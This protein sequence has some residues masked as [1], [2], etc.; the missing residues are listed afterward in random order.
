MENLN[1]IEIDGT[2]F[3]SALA[4]E[5]NFEDG[6]KLKPNP[7]LAKDVFFAEEITDWNDKVVAEN[8]KLQIKEPGYEP[9][10][11]GKKWL[12]EWVLCAPIKTVVVTSIIGAKAFGGG[13]VAPVIT[14]E[15]S[16]KPPH[17]KIVYKYKWHAFF[18]S[19]IKFSSSG[20][21]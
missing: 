11:E 17:E 18:D 12:Q 7:D 15:T 4:H 16:R 9:S 10:L 8:P 6:T 19:G 13:T 5:L 14:I 1:K 3:I 21:R 20:V 2:V